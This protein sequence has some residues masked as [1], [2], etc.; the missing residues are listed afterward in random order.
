MTLNVDKTNRSS[1]HSTVGRACAPRRRG[2]DFG[3]P[4]RRHGLGIDSIGALVFAWRRD[5]RE[6]ALSLQHGSPR[7][8]LVG[9]GKSLKFIQYSAQDPVRLV[10]VSF[11]W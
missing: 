6:A 8:E 4:R 2:G 11:G 5:S 1:R 9:A 10:A 3:E 7:L